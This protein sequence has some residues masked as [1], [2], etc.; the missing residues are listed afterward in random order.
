MLFDINGEKVT[1]RVIN[2]DTLEEIETVDLQ[3][4]VVTWLKPLTPEQILNVNSY[5]DFTVTTIF[6]FLTVEELVWQFCL[7]N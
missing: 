7:N 5:S 2:P 1:L 3:N 6:I 4:G